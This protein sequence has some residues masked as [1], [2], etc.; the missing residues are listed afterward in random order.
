MDDKNSAMHLINQRPVVP[1]HNSEPR[2]KRRISILVEFPDP[3]L[4][5]IVIQWESRRPTLLVQVKKDSNEPVQFPGKRLDIPGNAEFVPDGKPISIDVPLKGFIDPSSGRLFEKM[6]QEADILFSIRSFQA[7]QPEPDLVLP[8]R[9]LW[10][11][12]AEALQALQ[13]VDQPGLGTDGR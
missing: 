1:G 5:S 13:I 8:D 10:E 4:E 2:E 7:L 6:A 3:T 12:R 11:C 9:S